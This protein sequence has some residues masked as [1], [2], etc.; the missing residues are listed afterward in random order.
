[1]ARSLRPAPATG[2]DTDTVIPSAADLGLDCRTCGACCAPQRSDAV[3]VGVTAADIARMSRLWR[4]RHVAR[5]AILTKLDPVGRCVCVAL[6]GAIGQRVSCT[7]YERRP[8]ECRSFTAGTPE[9]HKARRQAGL[10]T[11]R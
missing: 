6:R 8:S 11:A 5:D 1:V 4:E 10:A 9:C 2:T 3:Y 7:I